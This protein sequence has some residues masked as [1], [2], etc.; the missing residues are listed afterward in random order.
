ML[1]LYMVTCEVLSPPDAHITIE[2][3]PLFSIVQDPLKDV[4]PESLLPCNDMVFYV[5]PSVIF[6]YIVY[7]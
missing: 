7:S 3:L 2:Q 6:I 4:Q 5:P 1:P